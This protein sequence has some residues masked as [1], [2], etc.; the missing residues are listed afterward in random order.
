MPQNLCNF[1]TRTRTKPQAN[2]KATTLLKS[3]DSASSTAPM[4]EGMHKST[5]LDTSDT[6][7]KAAYA[8]PPVEIGTRGT[9]ASLIMQE[10]EYFSRI[11]SNSQRNKSQIRNVGSS[12][13]TNSRSTIVSTV[14][15]TKKKRGSSSKLLPNMCSMVDVSENNRP[16]RTSVFSYRNLRS[17]SDTKNFQV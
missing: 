2:A 8:F 3:E 9:V 12:V 4:K 6:K 10:I 14:E 13:S 5:T 16:N 17:E 1:P 7:E 15:S 11:E